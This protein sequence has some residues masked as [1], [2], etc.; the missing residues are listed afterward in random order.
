VNEAFIEVNRKGGGLID[1]E[2][3]EFEKTKPCVQVHLGTNTF[4]TVQDE[5]MWS[6]WNKMIQAL[7]GRNVPVITEASTEI[8]GHPLFGKSKAA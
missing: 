6:I 1:V 2:P 5:P 3:K 4:V 8:P 7:G